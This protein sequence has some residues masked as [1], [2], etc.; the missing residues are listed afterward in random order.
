MNFTSLINTRLKDSLFRWQVRIGYSIIIGY[1]AYYIV[2]LNFSLAIPSLMAEYGYTKTEL[3]IVLTAFSLI[4]GIGKFVAG[5]ICDRSSSKQF[6]IVGLLGAGVINLIMGFSAVPLT[7]TLLLILWTLNSGFQS[8]GWPPCARLLTYWFSPSEIGTAWGICNSAHAVGSAIVAVLAGY[9]IESY[10]WRSAFYIPALLAFIAAGFL[11]NRVKDSPRDAGFDLD[12]RTAVSDK[13]QDDQL[14][15]KTII[16]QLLNNPI[17]WC[18]SLGNMFLYVVRMGIV[19]WIPTFLFESKGCTLQLAGIQFAGFE[20]LGILGGIVAGALSDKVP[21]GYRSTIA[22][23]FLGGLF[24][25]LFCIYNTPEGSPLLFLFAMMSAGFFLYGPQILV[26]VVVTDYVSK[27]S[28]AAASGL[29]GTFGYIGGALGG[30]GVGW[31]ADVSSWQGVFWIFMISTLLSLISFW[32]AFY[33]R[34]TTRLIYSA[35]P[36][37]NS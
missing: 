14:S 11:Y 23:F 29:T 25:G 36:L 18:M 6:F 33:F 9:L 7:L 17:I 16:I 2:R 35:T 28:A 8:M 3:G 15:Y 5:L 37:R 1:A 31:V 27:E 34:T 20:I 26:G 4:Y 24:T 32:F 21:N 13:Q 12:V 19:N 22:V 10:G 30:M